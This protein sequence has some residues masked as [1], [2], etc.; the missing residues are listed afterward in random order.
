MGKAVGCRGII[1][2]APREA[3]RDSIQAASSSESHPVLLEP[4]LKGFGN[5]GSFL[6]QRQILA[7]DAALA[8]Q[9]SRNRKIVGSFI[10]VVS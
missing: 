7:E 6:D 3:L 2:A 1:H 5:V 8:L 4:I 9:T 10:F